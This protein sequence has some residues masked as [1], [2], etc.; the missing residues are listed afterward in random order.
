MGLIRRIAD[1]IDPAPETRTTT[2]PWWPM[3][4]WL[5][6]VDG[7]RVVN[8][9]IAENLAT[10]LACVSAISSAIASLP[11]FVYRIT[12]AGREEDS[13]HP[14][15]RLIRN[16]PNEY[17]TWPDFVEW[18]VASTLLRGNG[19]AEIVTDGGGRVV[20]LK[21]IPWEFVSVQ[22]LPNGRL[23]YDIVATTG[24]YGA[25]GKLRRLLEGEV[26]HLR[27]RSDDGFCGR[28]RLSRA[29]SVVST[30][31][32]IQEFSGALYENG[33]HPSGVLQAEGK[34]NDTQLQ[35]LADHFRNTFAGPSK[36]AKALVLDQG[37]EWKSVSI[38]PEDAQVLETR[39]FTS[40]EL[41]RLY[42]VPPPIIGNL[43]FG[44]FTNSETLIRFFAQSTLTSWCR[45]IEAEFHRS[46][47]SESSRIDRQFVL[48]LSGLLRGDPETRWKSH[49][50]ALRNQV[51]TPNEIRGEEGW[52]PRPDGDQVIDTR[53]PN[54]AAA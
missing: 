17:Q 54:V 40:E 50:I 37:L 20:E 44:T 32:A 43:Q 19:L 2:W 5:G 4:N 45:K 52:N 46:V 34:L 8:A 18:L 10:V 27:D 51:L 14:I 30:A 3:P 38:S 23:V 26:L 35:R 9:R 13:G 53:T 24:F 22:L 33:A 1:F 48:D 6:A 21:C 47:L 49:E 28:S 12:D 42:Q 11:A 31:L 29:A 39:R 36:T 25:T 16:G 15:S 41:S 7:G